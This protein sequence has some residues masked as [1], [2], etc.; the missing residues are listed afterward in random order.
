MVST[1]ETKNRSLTLAIPC[2]WYVRNWTG[3]T[4][5]CCHC[6]L[7]VNRTKASARGLLEPPAICCDAGEAVAR[8][9]DPAN[10]VTKLAP[11]NAVP[12]PPTFRKL[13]REKLLFSNISAPPFTQATACKGCSY[14][15]C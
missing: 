8:A 2:G 13:R 14:P 1:D 12:A 4:A 5:T 7:L 9:S 11:S 10:P 6:V 3:T 15:D